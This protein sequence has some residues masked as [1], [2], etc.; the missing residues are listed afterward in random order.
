MLSRLTNND[1]IIGLHI[2]S[3]NKS[4]TQALAD[5]CFMFYKH[6][7]TIFKGDACTGPICISFWIMY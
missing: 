7:V 3:A 6:Q 2:S 4:V 1:D 5:D